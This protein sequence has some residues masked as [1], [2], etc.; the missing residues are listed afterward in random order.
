M[1]GAPVLQLRDIHAA[2][3]PEF[4]PPAPGWW[5]LALLCLVLLAALGYCVYRRYRRWRR[6]RTA[7]EALAQFCNAAA[8]ENDLARLAAELSVLLRRVALARFS[9][10]AV[11]GL[12]GLD[13]LIFRDATG[14]CGRFSNGPGKVLLTA[15]YA[16]CADFDAQ[17][18]CALVKDWI[19]QNA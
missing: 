6:Q 1:N 13:W 4:W 3:P 9:R 15:P 17:S 12:S 7:L 2:P 5:L 10:A 16:P 19:K 11:A 14:G 18:L 8:L